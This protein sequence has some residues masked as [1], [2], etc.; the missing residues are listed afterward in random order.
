[1]TTTTLK[2]FATCSLRGAMHREG[3]GC[4]GGHVE[5]EYTP[6]RGLLPQ[7]K[8]FRVTTVAAVGGSLAKERGRTG[9]PTRLNTVAQQ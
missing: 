2:Q 4:N 1:M 6:R 8:T 3:M 5:T 7:H 9:R